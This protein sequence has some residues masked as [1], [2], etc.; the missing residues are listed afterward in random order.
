MEIDPTAV[1]GAPVEEEEGKESEKEQE[2]DK[3]NS[4]PPS[5]RVRKRAKPHKGKP[6]FGP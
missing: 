3:E 6:G 5:R 4:P 2:M 1:L